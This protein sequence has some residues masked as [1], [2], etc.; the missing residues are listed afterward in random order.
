[1]SYDD[2]RM[3]KAVLAGLA[4]QVAASLGDGWSP[5][6]NDE[7]GEHWGT[8]LIGPPVNGLPARV[9]FSEPW[10]AKGRLT[11]SGCYPHSVHGWPREVTQWEITV[12]PSRGAVTIGKEITRRLLPGYL[13]SLR[14]VAETITA[15]T[16]AACARRDTAA[17]LAVVLGVQLPPESERDTSVRLPVH[18]GPVFG[19]VEVG[20]GGDS[21]HVAL[22]SVPVAAAEALLRALTDTVGSDTQD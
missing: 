15:R 9:L 11:L 2:G 16:G 20:Y 8:F 22:H 4:A 21:A 3:G 12:N 7:A 10:N 5:E 17:R 13:G 19:H 18:V 6:I 1:M 14:V